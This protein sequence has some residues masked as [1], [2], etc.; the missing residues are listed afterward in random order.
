MSSTV[1]ERRRMAG[2]AG[3]VAAGAALRNCVVTKVLLRAR[4]RSLSAAVIA[5]T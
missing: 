2:V 1:G 5:V 4:L 3:G